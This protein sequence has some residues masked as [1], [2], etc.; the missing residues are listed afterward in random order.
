[1]KIDAE[2]ALESV[3]MAIEYEL[4]PATDPTKI[5]DGIV[6][7]LQ[8]HPRF[9]ELKIAELDLLLADLKREFARDMCEAEWRLYSAFWTS[10]GVEDE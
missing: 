9:H 3:L 7:K 2:T 1:M 6:S 10:L 8:K 4:V 5:F